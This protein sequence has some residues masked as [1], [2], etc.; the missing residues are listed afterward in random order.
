[1]P[2]LGT[3]YLTRVDG[4]PGDRSLTASPGGRHGE[5][6]EQRQTEGSFLMCPLAGRGPCVSQAQTRTR[7]SPWA[8][9]EGTHPW[10][11]GQTRLSPE[12][13]QKVGGRGRQ[14]GLLP[15]V[16]Q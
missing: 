12:V 4:V 10:A 2:P 6:S 8:A 7:F 13:V 9:A 5:Q 16:G 14:P 15:D 1:M 3:L 11:P